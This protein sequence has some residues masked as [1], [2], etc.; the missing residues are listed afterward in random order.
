MDGSNS[1]PDYIIVGGPPL[2]VVVL[3]SRLHEGD[4]ALKIL[5]I[6][7]RQDSKDH[8]LIAAQPFAAVANRDRLREID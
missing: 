2:G 6:E 5:L 3:G 8:P 7:A 1:I 4:P